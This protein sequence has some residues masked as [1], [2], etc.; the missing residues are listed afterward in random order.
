MIFAPKRIIHAPRVAL[1]NIANSRAD[2]DSH[3][4]PEA[5]MTDAISSRPQSRAE[6][7]AQVAARLE[8]LPFTRYQFGILAV[9]ATAWFFDS[10]DLGAL[11][12]LLGSIAAEFHLT[13][14]AAGALSSASFL[15]MC[16][17]AGLAGIA[18][19]RFG[20]MSVFQVSMLFWGA[21]SLL[22]GI[23]QSIQMLMLA[24]IVVGFGMG[25]EFPIAQAIA[26][27]LV[28]AQHRGRTLALLEGFWPIGF[29]T[30]GLIALK[31]L[32]LIGWRWVF[33]LEGLPACFVFVVRYKIPELP[34]W[35]ADHGDYREAEETMASM[36]ESVT[37]HLKANGRTLPPPAPLTI[38]QG[39][40]RASWTFADLWTK[41]YRR[42]TTMLWSLWF[43]ALL[44]YYGLTTWLSALLQRNGYSLTKS[45][46][47]TLLISLAG[48]PGFAV[49]SWL[50]EL[51][52]RRKLCIITLLGSAGSAYLYGTASDRAHLIGFGLAMQFFLFAMWSVL[53]AYTAEL[54]P[55]HAR[56]TG[57][58][59]ASASGRVG[60]LIAPFVVG[61]I[62][63]QVGQYGVFALGAVS[64]LFAALA[65]LLFGK[66]SKGKTVEEIAPTGAIR[67][68]D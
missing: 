28:P 18:A 46:E 60:S 53:Y 65:V 23:S 34:R 31:F 42:S 19:D 64:F 58:G 51:V 37:K 9:I 43:F 63:P 12:F 44:G 10:I 3:N 11:T 20:R 5:T 8:R 14:A 22:C 25:M 26:S 54:Y 38:Q 61:V 49:A 41:R 52:G 40:L 2:H 1:G 6:A 21:G 50:I 17:G 16:I 47:Y 32:P 39:E 7:V 35:L 15:G 48:I 24:R 68:G 67:A 66:E 59:F 57:A 29:I 30:A 62:L 45:V 55:T 33:V 27:E 13:T 56:A 4:E 36:E